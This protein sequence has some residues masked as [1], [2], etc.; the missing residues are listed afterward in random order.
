[1]PASPTDR[2]AVL[3]DMTGATIDAIRDRAHDRA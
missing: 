1:L 3:H 2:R